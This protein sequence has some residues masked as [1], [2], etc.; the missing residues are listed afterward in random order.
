MRKNKAFFDTLYCKY[1]RPEL[2]DPDP[3]A[4]LAR[5]PEVRER[6]VAALLAACFAYGNVKAIVRNLE[7]LFSLMPQPRRYLLTATPAKLQQDFSHFKY[8]FTD[9]AELQRFLLH[10]QKILR[11]YGSLEACFT[12]FLRK[13]DTTFYPALTQFAHCLRSTQEKNTLVPDPS[14]GSALKRLNLF[15]RWMIRRDDVDPGGWNVPARLLIVP[16]DV[17]M[18]RCARYLGLT[19][20]NS[21]DL[22]TALEITRAL[23]RFSPEDPVKYDFCI[24]RFGIRPDMNEQALAAKDTQ[25]AKQ[26]DRQTASCCGQNTGRPRT[27]KKK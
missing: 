2:I 17:H 15:L 10:I 11:T 23:A 6:E 9:G 21:A 22:K 12:H 1:N 5:W 8:R 18:H 25:T 14:K 19:H 27:R 20:R 4:L 26:L 16:L 3:L 7:K 13:E 24:T